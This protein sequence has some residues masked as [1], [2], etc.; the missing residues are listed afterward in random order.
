MAHP[1]HLRHL[2]LLLLGLTACGSG[3]DPIPTPVDPEL[4]YSFADGFETARGELD[5]LFPADD[6]RWSNQQIVNPD[7]GRNA[8][9]IEGATVQTGNHALRVLASPT[10]GPLS[11]ADIEKGGFFAPPGSTVEIQADIFLATTA[12]L[13]ELFLIDLE[14]CSCWD[15]DVPDNQC[16]GIRLKL[17]GEEEYLAIE[18][19]KIL[20]STLRQTEWP[21]PKNEW[22]R[23]V[24][25][26]T[27]SPDGGG[28]N[29]LTVN[30]ERIIDVTDKNLPNSAEFRAEFARFGIDFELPERV[31]YERVQIGATANPG[32]QTA[33]VL[34]DNFELRITE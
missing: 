2:C 24:W 33:Q 4:P 18:R 15:P 11:K 16:P 12:N 19:G 7:G 1:I 3:D 27:L 6:S 10:A 30:G 26:M 29:Q 14:C 17:A 25:S 13:A 22:V 28:R 31:G 9:T 34:F 23:V 5:E 8:I 32:D 20:G 21:F